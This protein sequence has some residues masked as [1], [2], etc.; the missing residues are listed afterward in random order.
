MNRCFNIT[1]NSMNKT[2]KK[3]W[4]NTLNCILFLALWMIIWWGIILW[5][6]NSILYKFTQIYESKYSK[7]TSID[8]LLESEFYDQDLLNSWSNDMIE[9]ALV[10]YVWALNDP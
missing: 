9:W 2:W 8:H 7:F 5:K 1:I 3:N 4:N 10:W 6:Q